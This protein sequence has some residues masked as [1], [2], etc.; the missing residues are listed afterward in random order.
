MRI[1]I[2]NTDYPAF[3]D[4]HYRG[5][6]AL[7]SASY[8]TQM[9][10]R[11][12]SLFGSSDF[13]SRGLSRWGCEAIEIHANNPY[14]QAAW[15]REQGRLPSGFR[16]QP[17]PHA[18]ARGA[19]R[20]LR[21]LGVPISKAFRIEPWMFDILA[22]QIARFRPDVVLN[23]DLHLVPGR[24]LR[25]AT[26]PTS[27]IVGQL[28]APLP[29][30]IDFTAYDLMISSLP[31][32][33]E[34]FRTLGVAAEHCAL[35]FE[36]EILAKAP[37]P[38]ARSGVVFVGNFSRDH[39]R[40]IELMEWLCANLD[41]IEI[42]GGGLAALDRRS[43][44][45][46]KHRGEAYGEAMYRILARAAIGLNVHIDI[47]DVHANNL[48]LYE[49]TG[50]GALLLTDEQHDLAHLF[51]PNAEVATFADSR[52]CLARIQYFL[53]HPDEAR[54]IAERGQARTLK[55]Y[56]YAARMGQLVDILETHRRTGQCA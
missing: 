28:A 22:A 9:A 14:M 11:N 10:A 3:L 4:R 5:Q 42:W 46:S 27:L 20:V 36:P 30:A 1:L 2:V 25:E 55:D 37:P 32:L 18:V 52:Q 38:S 24:F 34:R 6:T 56:N 13:Y 51:T 8:A 21:R 49:V 29:G 7:C 31:N 41:A 39:R 23:H 45:R 47:A 44:I 35:A 19:Q 17:P 16:P 48:R 12:D 26:G 50:M 40:R 53:A 54:V 33:V 15:G 43:P